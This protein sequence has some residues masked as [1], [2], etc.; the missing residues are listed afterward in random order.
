MAIALRVPVMF[1]FH[2]RCHHGLAHRAQLL[3]GAC[4]RGFLGACF[5]GALFSSGEGSAAFVMAVPSSSSDVGYGVCLGGAIFFAS[6]FS[7]LPR[8][9]PTGVRGV[10]V[11]RSCGFGVYRGGG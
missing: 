3:D 9:P 10:R 7:S 8:F 6:V 5:G 4:F 2:A 1:N 11:K